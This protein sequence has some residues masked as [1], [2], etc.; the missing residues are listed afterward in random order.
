MPANNAINLEN[1][2]FGYWLVLNRN[3][4]RTKQTKQAYWDCE[5]QLCH[6]IH[7]IRGT[8]LRNGKSTRCADCAK[9]ARRKSELGNTYGQLT[10]IKELGSIN[11]RMMWLCKCSCGN[12]ITVS[13]TDLR[14]L[15]VQ[16]CGKCPDRRSLGE[17]EIA[18][19]LSLNNIVYETEYSF[20][21]LKYENG[22]K[23]RFDF[24]LPLENCIIE[25]D[26]KQHYGYQENTKY[27]NNKENYEKTVIRDSIKNNYCIN[28]NITIIRIPYYLQ[29]K[30]RLE[31]LLPNSSKYKIEKE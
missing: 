7:T 18:A 11:N 5:C 2:Q 20:S 30:I 27:W 15:K 9:K 4:E 25:F 28:H 29:S 31:D 10:V 16:S 19:I 14:T 12:E 3:E 17:K 24:Y 22:I 8:Q 26:G 6:Q 21:D 1:Q 13:G 23:P